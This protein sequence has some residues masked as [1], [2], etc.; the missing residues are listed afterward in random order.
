MTDQQSGSCQC[1]AVRYIVSGPLLYLIPSLRMTPAQRWMIALIAV[2]VALAQIKQPFPDIA[3]LQHIPT[4]ILL[5]AAPWLLKRWP[6]SNGAVGCITLFL[7]L[8]TLGGRYTYSNVPYDDWSRA[9]TG[10]SISQLLGTTR[11]HYDRLVHLAFGVLAVRPAGEWLRCYA[12][13]ALRGSLIGAIGY[14]LAV[15]CLYEMFE[16]FLTLVLA[17]PL[18]EDY[19]GQQGD[20][21][22]PQKDMAIA[23]LGAMIVVVARWRG[24]RAGG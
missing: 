7:L 11:N 24:E 17:G 21:W 8:H 4:V 6:L 18:S 23:A 10:T 19:N 12:G 14:V 3:P 22:D 2:A 9:L 16:W 5:I 15:S 1:G 13:R 20:M